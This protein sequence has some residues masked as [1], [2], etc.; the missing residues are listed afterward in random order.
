MP[1]V[2]RLP[3]FRVTVTRQI[4]PIQVQLQ[5]P[6]LPGSLPSSPTWNYTYLFSYLFLP[7]LAAHMCILKKVS[8]PQLCPTL[9]NP[10]NCSLPGFFVLVDSPGKNTGVGCHA[11]LQGILPTQGLNL[12]LLHCRQII[13]H[14]EP[15]GKTHAFYWASSP[16]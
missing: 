8:V 14:L 3:V 9:C 16:P 6:L 2:T 1:L 11:L 7:G 10:M 12:G 4:L 13:Y 15:P 5:I